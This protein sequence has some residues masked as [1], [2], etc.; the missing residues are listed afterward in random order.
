MHA[1]SDFEGIIPSLGDGRSTEL[2]DC[3]VLH[4]ENA[5]DK[6]ETDVVNRRFR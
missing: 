5:E 6:V 3:I 2:R 1:G 4:P